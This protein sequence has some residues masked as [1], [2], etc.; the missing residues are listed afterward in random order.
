MPPPVTADP[1]SCPPGPT[2]WP[3][4][5]SILPPPTSRGPSPA[6]PTATAR[7]RPPW[8]RRSC[9][10]SSR[11]SRFSIGGWRWCRSAPSSPE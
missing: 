10:P 8:S 7:C 1:P 5:C 4:A 9:S 11:H 6:T 3:A 2:P